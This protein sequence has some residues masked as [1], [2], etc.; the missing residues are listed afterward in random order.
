MSKG[1]IQK[2]VDRPKFYGVK[3]AEKAKAVH[4]M[5]LAVTEA[6]IVTGTHELAMYER[7]FVSSSGDWFFSRGFGSGSWSLATSH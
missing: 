4:A 7:T 3:D 6:P 2:A 1:G 5:N